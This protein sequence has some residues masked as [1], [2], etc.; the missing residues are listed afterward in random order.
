MKGEVDGENTTPFGAAMS[1]TTLP[2]W[3][4]ELSLPA[5][6]TYMAFHA[7]IPV[8]DD[9]WRDFLSKMGQQYVSTDQCVRELKAS[10]WMEVQA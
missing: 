7:G 9:V 3:Q 1:T 10:G 6:L 2:I 5:K 8:S 4:T